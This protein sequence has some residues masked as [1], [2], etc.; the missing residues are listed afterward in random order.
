MADPI[1]P[2]LL[3][4]IAFSG[5]NNKALAEYFEVSKRE[6]EKQL[7]ESKELRDA[8]EIGRIKYRCCPELHRLDRKR[9]PHKWKS[10]GAH[11][12]RPVQGTKL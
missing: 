1:D 3:K 8:L 9:S 7:S 6:F 4:I 10:T 12:E 5:D 11:N 2:E